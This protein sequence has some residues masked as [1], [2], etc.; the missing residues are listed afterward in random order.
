MCIDDNALNLQVL[1]DMLKSVGV[2]AWP[3]VSAEAGLSGLGARDY[4]MILTDLRMPG[5]DG[6]TFIEH[7]RRHTDICKSIPIIVI[8]ADDDELELDRCRDAGASSVTAKPV[9]MNQLFECIGRVLVEACHGEV[10]T[11]L[12]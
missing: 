1:T 11:V 10:R 4:D 5:M 8:T 7:V 3:F 2:S 6:I 12:S 9:I